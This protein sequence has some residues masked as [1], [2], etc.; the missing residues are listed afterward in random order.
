MGHTFILAPAA[1]YVG[2]FL[3]TFGAFPPRQRPGSFT[4]APSRCYTRGARPDAYDRRG[5]ERVTAQPRVLPLGSGACQGG[6]PA[7]NFT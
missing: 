1:G 3:S 7:R 6:P 2:D 4:I 5:A